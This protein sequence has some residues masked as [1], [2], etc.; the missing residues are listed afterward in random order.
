MKKFFAAA[1]AVI[2]LASVTLPASARRQGANSGYCPSGSHGK[3]GKSHTNNL[4][5]CHK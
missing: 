1:L 2:A 3:H 4:A 5:N